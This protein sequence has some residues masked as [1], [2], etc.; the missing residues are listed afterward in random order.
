MH[1]HS[2]MTGMLAQLRACLKARG[3][4]WP[5]FSIYLFISPFLPSFLLSMC[6]LHAY[7]FAYACSHMCVCVS[8][9]V[10]AYMCAQVHHGM[11]M[12]TRTTCRNWFSW[13]TMW[14][15]GKELRLSGL[16]ANYPLSLWPSHLLP[17]LTRIPSLASQ[18]APR[19]PATSSSH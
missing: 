12:E 18:L 3:P 7:V 15:R 14:I 1:G 10:F 8:L 17:E 2:L 4:A 9:S 5:G 11:S 19:I 16:I 6:T 13:S